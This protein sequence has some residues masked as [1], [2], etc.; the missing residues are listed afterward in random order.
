MCVCVFWVVKVCVCVRGGR[1]SKWDAGPAADA[2]V[3]ASVYA[4]M[5]VYVCELG[6]KSV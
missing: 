5:C 2:D 3:A 6:G 4:C 1:A